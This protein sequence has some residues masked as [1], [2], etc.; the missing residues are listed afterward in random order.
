[1]KKLISAIKNFKIDN[2]RELMTLIKSLFR[3]QNYV[4]PQDKAN[5]IIYGSLIFFIFYLVSGYILLGLAISLIVGLV[6]EVN[7]WNKKGEFNW[8]DIFATVIVPVIV[9]VILNI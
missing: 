4:I 3:K 6:N 8:M 5:H 2:G 9:S 1:M 7:D